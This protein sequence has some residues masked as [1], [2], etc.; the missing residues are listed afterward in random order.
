MEFNSALP[1]YLQVVTAIKRE[2]VIGAIG[3]GEKLPSGRDLAIRYTINPNTA[4]RVYKELESEGICFTRRGLGTFVSEDPE[5]ISR[6]KA[7]MAQ[8]LLQQFI[9][10]MSRLGITRAEAAEMI[11]REE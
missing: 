10:G 5:L 11:R 6:M 8:E 3:L 1:I 7:E 2:I 4:S 9:D